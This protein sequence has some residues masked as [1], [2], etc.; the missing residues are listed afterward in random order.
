MHHPRTL[1]HRPLRRF[2]EVVCF[3]VAAVLWLL[4]WYLDRGEFSGTSGHRTLALLATVEAVALGCLFW[5]ENGHGHGP[6]GLRWITIAWLSIPVWA[7]VDVVA[8]SAL[9]ATSS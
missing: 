9:R 6:A 3:V 7:C 2:R 1:R 8:A 4:A 5:R